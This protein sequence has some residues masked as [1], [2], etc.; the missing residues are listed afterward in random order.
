MLSEL[1][2]YTILSGTLFYA[3][4]KWATV[5]KEYFSKRNIKHFHPK[6]LIGNTIGLFLKQYTPD[7]FIDLLYY[8]YPK[9][10]Y[11]IT[12]QKYFFCIEKIR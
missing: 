12:K 1:L 4:Y 2:F 6:F 9:E 10:K 11:V 3:F 5:N 7:K 8:R